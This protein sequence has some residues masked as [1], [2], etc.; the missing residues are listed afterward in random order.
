VLHFGNLPR[1]AI[2]GPGFSDTDLSLI[3]NVA[4]AGQAHLQFR[5]EVF[6]LF[7]VA[8]FGQPGRTATVGSTSFG[9]ITN[10]RFPTGDSGSS[11]QVQFAA[12]FLF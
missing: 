4:L 8:N 9:V 7:N 5:V 11:R 1:N 2:V 12:K 6:N 10:T 3:K